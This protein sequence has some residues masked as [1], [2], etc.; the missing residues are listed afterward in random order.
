MTTVAIA[1]NLNWQEEIIAA[2][3]AKGNTKK[4]FVFSEEE[5][6]GFK[7]TIYLMSNPELWAKIE[8]GF[9]TPLEECLLIDEL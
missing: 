5:L 9:N 3:K 2:A 1:N 4:I 8:K 6:S 7:E